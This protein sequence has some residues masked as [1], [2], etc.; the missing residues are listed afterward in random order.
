MNHRECIRL[1]GMRTAFAEG[2]VPR[3][4]P[5]DLSAPKEGVILCVQ[6]F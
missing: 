5:A 2:D 6:C 3:L 4:S 1:S